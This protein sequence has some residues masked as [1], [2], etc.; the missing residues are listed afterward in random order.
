MIQTLILS[1]ILLTLPSQAEGRRQSMLGGKPTAEADATRNAS[2]S[3]AAKVDAP[4]KAAAAPDPAAK[5]EDNKVSDDALA[6]YNGLKEKTP[7]TVAA[8]SKL[9]AWCE[10]HGLKA[11]AYVHYAAVVRLDPRREAA[12]R[13]LG[14]KKYGNRWMTE[15]QI[16]EAEEQK[17]Q[18]RIWAPQLKRIH[19]DIHGSNG[20]R[21]RDLARS[22]FEAIRDERAIPSLYREFGSSQ[23]DQLMLIE[24][25]NRIEKPL[26]T[27][28]LAMLAVYGRTPEVRRHATEVLRGRSATDYLELLVGLLVDPIKYEVK[29]V[30]GPGSP[31]VLFVE[32]TQFNMARFYAPPPPPNIVPRPGDIISYDRAGMPVI[33]RD[34][35]Q[36]PKAGVPGSKTLAFEADVIA[37]YSASEMMLQAEQGAARAE[38]QLQGD[39]AQVKSVN[40]ARR[41]FNELV[42]SVASYATGKTIGLEPEDWR[43]AV[44]VGQKYS[45][46]PKPDK[47]T[48][49]ELVPL[50]YQ[51]TFAQLGFMYRVFYDT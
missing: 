27:R 51:P 8:Q 48:I 10:E 11:E 43:K 3:P 44:K 38:A 14:Y 46:E 25:L 36:S 41:H 12:W 18:D 1:S 7:N 6:E 47:P 49:T 2:K 35:G 39:V 28:V 30:G 13:K 9:A 20:A 31:G 5:A 26:A 50:A 16:A 23:T 15:A 22:A 24:A 17:K 34:L 21:K 42:I 29:P 33:T 45:E 40:D 37:Q 32:G 4:K 19:K